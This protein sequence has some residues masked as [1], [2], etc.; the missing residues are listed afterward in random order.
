MIQT[1]TSFRQV[2]ALRA[3][4]LVDHQEA[5]APGLA[6]GSEG[7]I[8]AR[9]DRR[10]AARGELVEEGL[11]DV[12]V[13]RYPPPASP[14]PQG[15][16]LRKT[17]V[18]CRS[19]RSSPGRGRGRRSANRSGRWTCPRAPAGG[20]CRRSVRLRAAPARPSYTEQALVSGDLQSDVRR[21]SRG[22]SGI[23]HA[24]TMLIPTQ[25]QPR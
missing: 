12:Q 11:L 13:F 10:P 8:P 2:G 20:E 3:V 25:R 15:P 6:A 5:P 1:G 7:P 9:G 17:R 24:T 14:L 16:V 21:S 19:P 22:R 23:S 18:G 4:R